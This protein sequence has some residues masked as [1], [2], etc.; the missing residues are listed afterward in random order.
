MAIKTT[1]I[2]KKLLHR[3]DSPRWCDSC[4]IRIAPYERRMEVNGRHYHSGCYAKSSQA[5]SKAG[6]RNTPGSSGLS[7]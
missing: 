2:P 7:R 1:K 4:S 3:N 6:A 5:D